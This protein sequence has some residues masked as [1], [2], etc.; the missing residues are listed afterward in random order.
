M[1]NRSVIPYSN[2][3]KEILAL[4]TALSGTVNVIACSVLY[5]VSD[6]PGILQETVTQLFYAYPLLRAVCSQ[7]GAG[8]YISEKNDF[9]CTRT[10]PSCEDFNA[11]AKVQSGLSFDA[12]ECLTSVVPI[13]IESDK[14]E[15]FFLRIH[16]LV[17]DGCSIST[18][19]GALDRIYA[20]IKQENARSEQDAGL[21]YAQYVS[22][23]QAFYA[24]KRAE[25]ARNYWKN[26]FTQAKDASLIAKTNDSDYRTERYTSIIDHTGRVQLEAFARSHSVTLPALFTAAV[27]AVCYRLHGMENSFVGVLLLNRST[28]EEL[29]SIGNY[30][31][32]APLPVQIHASTGFGDLT[33]MVSGELMVLLRHQRLSYSHILKTYRNC[34]GTASR[35]FDVLISYQERRIQL[36]QDA[37]FCWYPPREQ[38][39]A[40]QIA[41]VDD[42]DELLIHYDYRP[43]CL[44]AANVK[45]FSKRVYSMLQDGMVN[46]DTPV[47][48]L[49]QVRPADLELL[50]KWNSTEMPYPGDQTLCSLFETKVN[51]IPNCT[52]LRFGDA[53]WSYCF[54]NE[55][56]NRLAHLLHER[57]AQPGDVVALMAERS[58]DLVLGVY[59]IQKCGAAYM[60]I[61]VD[62]PN[63]RIQFMLEDS[64]TPILLTQSKWKI[65]LPEKVTRVDMD[66][67]NLSSYSCENLGLAQPEY[68]AYVIYTSGSTGK[69]KGA[70]ISHRSAINRIHWMNRVFGM[71]SNDVILQKTPYTFDVSVWELFWWGMYGGTLAILPPEE[72]KDPDCI[73]KAIDF[74]A[75]TKMHFVPSMLAAFLE[76]I[77]RVPNEGSLASLKQVFASGEALMPAQVDRFYKLLPHAELINLYGPTECTVD[78]SCFRCPKKKLHSIPI[79]KPVD[80]TQLYIVD[81]QLSLLPIG[82]IGELCIAGDLVG[83]GYLKRP[84]LTADRFAPNPFGKGRLY[85]TG[86]LASW[87]EDGTIEYLGRIDFQVKLRGQRIELGEI[88][89]CLVEIPGIVQAV[90]TVQISA[91]GS[92]QLVAHYTSTSCMNSDDIRESLASKLPEY[93][94]PQGF[95][96]LNELPLTSS[97]KIDRKRL[98]LIDA[99]QKESKQNYIAP[100]NETQ[101][102][103]CKAFAQA[104]ELEP[105]QIGIHD[106]FFHLGGNS[107]RVIGLMTDLHAKYNLSL[108]EIYEHPTPAELEKLIEKRSCREEETQGYEVD[109]AY[110]QLSLK[111][112]ESAWH[113]EGSVLLT[114]ATGFLGGHLLHE[115]LGKTEA[116][117]YCLVRSPE[118]LR[119]HWEYLFDGETYPQDRIQIVQGD[120]TTAHLGLNED[121]YVRLTQQISAVFHAAAD[122]RHFGEWEPSYRTNALGTQHVVDFCLKA[123]AEL[124]HISTMS[125][126]GYVLTPMHNLRTDCFTEEMLYIGQQYRENVYVHSKYLAETI[127]L[128]AM[129]QGLQASI[130]RVGNLLWRRSD[131]KF[132]KN[133]EVHDFY[134]LTRAFT[135]LGMLPAE[136]CDLRV[137]LTAVDSCSEAILALATKEISQVYHM[138]NANDL[139]LNDYLRAVAD[140]P[141]QI[142]TMEKFV[143]EMEQYSDDPMMGFLLA[144]TTINEHLSS[145]TFPTASCERTIK[146]LQ[147]V[148]FEWEHPTAQY[149]RYCAE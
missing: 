28:P 116:C 53:S 60:P 29:A 57:G 13:M 51:E 77:E 125:V 20:S 2:S 67:A 114:G 24:G 31:N 118:K 46:V 55:R 16:H 107:I 134:M 1:T 62:Y 66:T 58:F 65:E 130:Y 47:D 115:L 88:E 127:V 44:S 26:V 6:R 59:A 10:F 122:V 52:A 9:V 7:D 12:D 93:M 113:G 90:A 121:V 36:N 143:H 38:V 3:Q 99:E 96:R 139:S 19:L 8:L 33:K 124:H 63:D 74:F 100:E 123:N 101:M 129:K 78:V 21:P 61:G 34:G 140:K 81:K 83:M 23:E 49:A 45:A 75:V 138:L 4:E 39:E 112:K 84:E 132:Q 27:S 25:R 30:F 149:V 22:D 48:Q 95:M 120:I 68:P 72:H 42:G 104:L 18:L 105:G 50:H 87:N 80:N 106:H 86:D 126:N 70:L 69:P 98:P 142:V 108:R 37:H 41:V 110:R 97:G 15:G 56:A 40:L 94:I 102:T 32:T 119:E 133:R 11:W 136:F 54:L 82:E 79:G 145:K 135:K 76:F 117:V 144:Y 137:D 89:R 146:R 17:C 71:D 43:S 92:E 131:L 85:R 73:R 91:L 64:E 35:L 141:I 5:P 128:D 109:E 147:H 103:L 148:G 111:A 14:R